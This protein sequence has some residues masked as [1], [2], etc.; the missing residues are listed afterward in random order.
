MRIFS[1]FKNILYLMCATFLILSTS[2]QAQDELKGKTLTVYL[3]IS[4]PPIS[5]VEGD[6]RYPKGF[7]VDIIHELQRR[8]GFELKDNRIFPLPRAKAIELTVQNK[9]DI[10]GGAMSYTTERAKLFDFSPIYYLTGMSI[11]YSTKYSADANSLNNLDGKTVAVM[12]GSTAEG[13]VK[14]VV[15]NA[16]LTIVTDIIS[17]YFLVAKGEVDCVVYDRM[18]LVFFV[19][20]MPHLNLAVS[21]DTFNQVDSQYAFGYPKNSPYSAIINR[22]IRNML[23]DG[24]MHKLASKWENK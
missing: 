18:P 5:Y 10:I 24:T 7:D 15:P 1:Q 6:F 21:N 22:E 12:K 20:A 14:R 4:S 17:A 9:A 3:D 16:K 2:T 8:L 11:M 13:Y 19:K 23:N